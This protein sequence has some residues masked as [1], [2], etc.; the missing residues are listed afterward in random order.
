MILF[1][2]WAMVIASILTAREAAIDR[3]RSEGRNLAVAFA[4]QVSHILGGVA[5]GMEIIAERMRAAHGQF[6]IYSWAREVPLLSSATIQGAIIGPDGRLVSTTLDPHPEPI[7]LSDREHFR[8]HLDGKFQG[9]FIGRPVAGR[10]S[11]RVT[12]NVTRRVATAAETSPKA[13][14]A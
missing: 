6:D 5:G 11:G 10:V 14:A 8:V 3:T 13:A 9:I 12:I 4:D 1:A 7:D 2:M